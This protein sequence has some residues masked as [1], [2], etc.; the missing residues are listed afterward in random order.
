MATRVQRIVVD[1]LDQ[2]IED[3]VGTYRFALQGVEYEIDLAKDNIDRLRAAMDPFIAAGRRLPKS[4]TGKGAT[5]EKR[6]AIRQWW[7]D[8]QIDLDLPAY[9]ARGVI[10]NQVKAAFRAAVQP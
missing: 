10:P 6:S 8:H 4:K 5:G 9:N 1:D 7:H 3:G 2:S